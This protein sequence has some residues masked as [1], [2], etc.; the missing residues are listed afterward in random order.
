MKLNTGIKKLLLDSF[1]PL[2]NAKPQKKFMKN[3]KFP[4]K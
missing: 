1:Q 4:K 2:Q 3:V